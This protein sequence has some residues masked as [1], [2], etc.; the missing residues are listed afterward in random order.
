MQPFLYYILG[1]HIYVLYKLLALIARGFVNFFKFI[2]KN[3]T[4]SGMIVY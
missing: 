4:L 2:A 3:F 1:L